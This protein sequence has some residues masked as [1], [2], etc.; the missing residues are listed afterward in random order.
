MPQSVSRN[1]NVNPFSDRSPED[2]AEIARQVGEEEERPFHDIS[3]MFEV[4]VRGHTHS[5]R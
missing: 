5:I 2:I 1:N 3:A 4:S